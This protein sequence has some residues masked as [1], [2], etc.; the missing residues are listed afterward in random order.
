MLNGLVLLFVTLSIVSW[1][2][3]RRIVRGTT[4]VLEQ[5]EF[6][7]RGP[8]RRAAQAGS[9]SATSCE[10]PRPDRRREPHRAG[11]IVAEISSATWASASSR[12]PPRC[13][14]PDELGYMILDGYKA[15]QAQPW[16]L[17]APCLA[18]A[19]ITLA[20]TFVGD[21][22]RDALDPREGR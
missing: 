10:R 14:V 7:D 19:S 13:P 3:S 11:A 15:W 12:R 21:G 4:L 22:L 6:V 17:V 16:M 20:F 2:G 18:V 9:S 8:R 1:T 5:Q